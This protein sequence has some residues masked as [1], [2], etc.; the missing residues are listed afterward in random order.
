MTDRPD[1]GGRD[2]IADLLGMRDIPPL[3]ERN[4]PPVCV[5]KADRGVDAGARHCVFVVVLEDTD[6]AMKRLRPMV[7]SVAGI[8]YDLTER[9]AIKR[10]SAVAAHA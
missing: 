4:S 1:H 8:A 9:D 3:A 5:S 6:Q 2:E 7:S 10:A